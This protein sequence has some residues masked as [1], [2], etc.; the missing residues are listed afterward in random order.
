M[1][2]LGRLKRFIQGNPSI[3][4]NHTEDGSK[5][6]FASALICAIMIV[7]LF[8]LGLLADDLVIT[9]S[10]IFQK[11]DTRALLIVVSVALIMAVWFSVNWLYRRWDQGTVLESTAS[12]D[13][14]HADGRFLLR[15]TFFILICWIPYII[16]RFPGN[17][18]PDTCQQ[19]L[20][21]YGLSTKSDHHPWFDT[22]VFSSF[23]K[24]GDIFGS[25]RVSLFLYGIIQMA[26]TAFTFAYT[27]LFLKK[28]GIGKGALRAAF[29]FWAFYPFVPALAQTM[30]KDMLNGWIYLLYLVFYLEYIRDAGKKGRGK[31]AVK[32]VLAGI[33]LSL[34]KKTGIYIFL[35]SSVLLVFFLYRSIRKLLQLLAEIFVVAFA[36]LFLWERVYLSAMGVKKG[37]AK[38][39]M[40]VPSQQITWYMTQYGDTLSTEDWEIL[41]AVYKDPKSMPDNYNPVR[42]DATK[43]RWRADSTRKDRIRF[44][45]LYF[46]LLLRHPDNYL[47]SFSAN[48]YPMLCVDSSSMGDESLLFYRDNIPPDDGSAE[49]QENVYASW[50]GNLA[51]GEDVHRIMKSSYRSVSWK[52]L[53]ETFN[54]IYNRIAYVASVLFSKVIFVTW[55]PL[56]VTFYAF[57]KKSWRMLLA[58]GP[59]FWSIMTLA[60]GPI[61]LPR[62]MV[63]AVYELP[64]LLC[65]PKLDFLFRKAPQT[66]K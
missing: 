16:I 25:H 3:K 29:L 12:Q 52:K 18:D 57:H 4:K 61:L 37:E 45:R 60:A 46:R 7:V 8:D 55:A 5:K 65:I 47:M 34:T 11:S 27:S 14:N 2:Q 23:W 43:D 31:N 32:F 33:F 10:M 28:C 41:S 9:K 53:S 49:G 26:A 59:I 56:L 1:I 6:I 13:G 20:E 64:L 48:I 44:Y 54:S 15:F 36:F 66:G 51:T 42:A 19:I 63:A 22:L 17:Y 62:Y 39:M 35:L 38:E 58:M 50:S 24:I 21:G 30:A 40:S